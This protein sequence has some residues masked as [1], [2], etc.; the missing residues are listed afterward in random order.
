MGDG[1]QHDWTP[2][3]TAEE[4]KY[5]ERQRRQSERELVRLLDAAGI[6]IEK[7]KKLAPKEK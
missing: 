3:T 6:D 4:V 5:R 7:L 2:P 1:R